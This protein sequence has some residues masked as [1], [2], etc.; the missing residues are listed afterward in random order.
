MGFRLFAEYY[1][2]R[3]CG[4]GVHA[5]G[6]EQLGSVGMQESQSIISTFIFKWILIDFCVFFSDGNLSSAAPG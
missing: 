4:G 6:G 5:P 1:G 2:H 3:R